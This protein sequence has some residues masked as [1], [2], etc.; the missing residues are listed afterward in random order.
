MELFTFIFCSLI[1]AFIGFLLYLLYL[2]LKIWLLKSGRLS[3][4]KSKKI[5]IIWFIIIV[6]FS[7]IF[8]YIA[9]YPDEEFYAEE[10]ETITLNKLP[11]SAEFIK[12]S[13]SYPDLHGDYCSAA[14]IKIS[15]SDYN[16]L[17]KELQKNRSFLKENKI[18][19]NSELNKVLSRKSEY[20][21]RHK[22]S[23]SPDSLQNKLLFIGFYND[24]K[25]III[26]H[27]NL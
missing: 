19:Y 23:K 21:L 6:L 11:K 27:C 24:N 10:Y 16:K 20:K 14:L 1:I 18:I 7:N 26:S 5:N 9:F 4:E 3:R 15:P 2:P 17:L 12:K 25:T 22:F 13:V 8:T